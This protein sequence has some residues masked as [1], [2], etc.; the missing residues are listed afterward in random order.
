VFGLALAVV[1][2]LAGPLAL[3][4]PWFVSGL[5]QRHAVADAFDTTQAE[6]DR[7]TSE[8][9]GDILLDGSFTAALGGDAPLLDAAE[10]SHMSDVAGLVRLL[11]AV[12]IGALVVAVAVGLQLRREPGRQG[13]IMV[14]AAGAIGVTAVVLAL[15]FAL[16]FDVAFTVFHELFFP[17]G[18]WQFAPGSN[19]ITLFPE[20]FWFEASLVAG[21]TIVVAAAVV[22][23]VGFVR[24]RGA[25]PD[26]PSTLN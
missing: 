15:V 8:L 6:I 17:P 10:R 4:N 3:F 1:I 25:R 5:Q 22:S 2:T 12:T 19:L 18:T 24:W 21:A 14:L 20:P 9:L 13:R 7:V 11:V 26:A 23:I 16:A